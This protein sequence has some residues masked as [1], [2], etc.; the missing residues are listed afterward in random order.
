[1]DNGSILILLDIDGVLNPQV[2]GRKLVLDPNRQE[3]VRELSRLGSVVWATTWS[4]A[5]TFH[6]TRDIGLPEHTEGIAFPSDLFAAGQ[7]PTSTPKLHWVSRWLERQF[8]DESLVTAVVWIDDQ[9]RKDVTVW[10]DKQTYPTLLVRPDPD[11][12]LTPK[13]VDAIRSFAMS[14]PSH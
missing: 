1:M 4:G 10:A 12:G 5:H 8:L 13:E 7:A 3:L 14:L 6:L 9:L 11:A 2:Q